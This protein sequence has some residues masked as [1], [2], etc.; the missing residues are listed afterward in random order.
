M[1]ALSAKLMNSRLA[2]VLWCVCAPGV[3][4]LCAATEPLSPSPES[5]LVDEAIQA[6]V[7][8]DIA[9]ATER[10]RKALDINPTMKRVHYQLAILA[11][12]KGLFAEALS[13]CDAEISLGSRSVDPYQLSGAIYARLQQYERAEAAFKKAAELAPASPRAWNNLSEIYRLQ[14]QWEQAAASF[15]EA[16]KLE[17]P[18]ACGLLKKQLITLSAGKVEAVDAKLAEFRAS[19]PCAPWVDALACAVAIQ[20][21]NP[22]HAAIEWKAFV[23][24]AKPEFI[25]TVRRDLFFQEAACVSGMEFL[26]NQL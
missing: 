16:E 20:K 21:K 5:R 11:F 25:E 6:E 18:D 3:F 2:F 4:L 14:H 22:V 26:K 17:Q 10:Y 19:P 1:L 23:G 13:E 9:G 8:G 24:R 15:E 12:Q 7:K